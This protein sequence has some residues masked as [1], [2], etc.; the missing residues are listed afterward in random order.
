MYMPYLRAEG[1]QCFDWIRFLNV[2]VKCIVM[3]ANIGL[4][5]RFDKMTRI[6]L[7]VEKISLKAIQRLDTQ[8]YAQISRSSRDMLKAFHYLIPLILGP[9]LAGHHAQTGVQRS[10]HQA[11]F[12]LS[13]PFD[14][15][16]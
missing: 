10:A 13:R 11:R 16:V 4:A 2:G 3:D 14:A 1:P 8:S 5:Y 7:G 6:R 9:S 12:K 15:S